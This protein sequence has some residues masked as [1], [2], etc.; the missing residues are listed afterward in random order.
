MSNNFYQKFG[1]F[2]PKHLLCLSQNK[3]RATKEQQRND[4]S[5][6]RLYEQRKVFGA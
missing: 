3:E 4:S 1:Y 5:E 6:K 2:D